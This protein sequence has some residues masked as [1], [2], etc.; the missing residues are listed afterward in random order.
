M[1][2]VSDNTMRKIETGAVIPKYDTLELLSLAYKVD[3]LA[4]FQKNRYDVSLLNLMEQVDEAILY[5]RPDEL[6]RLYHDFSTYLSKEDHRDLINAADLKIL[7][8]F[9]K[10]ALSYE[11]PDLKDIKRR[12]LIEE[13]RETLCTH[14]P[15]LHWNKLANAS[16]NLWEIRLLMLMALLEGSLEN[17][18]LSAR[19]LEAI[20]TR[21]KVLENLIVSEHKVFL[22]AIFN[23]AYLYHMMDQPQKALDVSEMGIRL[24]QKQGAFDILHGL[25]Y[26]KGVA[27]LLMGGEGYMA[28]LR[29][30]VTLLEIMDQPEAAQLYRDVT[31]E[32]YGL[33][34]P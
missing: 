17:Y 20:V 16:L 19:I 4:I 18:D 29:Y 22:T 10:T 1:V 34:I 28:P 31:L 21:Y 6:K 3:L 13:I 12:E 9:L 15:G 30:A 5:H 26:R 32:T 23:L 24:A 14:N 7:E 8:V 27:I 25:Y 11:D 33:I 2:G